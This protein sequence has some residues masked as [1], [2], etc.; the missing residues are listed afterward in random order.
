[1]D[2]ISGRNVMVSMIFR[3]VAGNV[4]GVGGLSLELS[5]REV[6]VGE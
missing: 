2:G 5:A 4:N 3:I 1:M 6:I